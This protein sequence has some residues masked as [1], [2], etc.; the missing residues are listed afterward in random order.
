VEIFF[1]AEAEAE[2]DLDAVVGDFA[3]FDGGGDPR[4]LGCAFSDEACESRARVGFLD[5]VPASPA[6]AAAAAAAGMLG[7][8]F[9]EEACESRAREAGLEDG[10]VFPAALPPAAAAAALVGVLAVAVD[11]AMSRVWASRA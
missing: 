7:C 9:S 2:A 6:A 1:L 5:G 10:V 3:G 11:V 8:A 4:M